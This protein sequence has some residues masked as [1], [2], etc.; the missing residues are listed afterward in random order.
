MFGYSH[1]NAIKNEDDRP[2]KTQNYNEGLAGYFHW[3][4]IDED[5]FLGKQNDNFDGF[6][7]VFHDPFELPSKFSRSM[8]TLMHNTIVYSIIPVAS[9]IDDSMLD[10]T[11]DE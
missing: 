5:T 8:R 7:M 4:E 3:K 6:S 9:K 2:F 11:A 10:F 1:E